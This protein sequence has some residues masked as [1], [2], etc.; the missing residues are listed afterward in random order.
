[1]EAHHPSSVPGINSAELECIAVCAIVWARAKP[2][3]RT[4]AALQWHAERPAAFAP[5]W[6]TE[7]AEII[8]RY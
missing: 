4:G 6:V 1:M 5:E 7:A 2:V 3:R 8:V